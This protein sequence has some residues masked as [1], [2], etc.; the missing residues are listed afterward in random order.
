MYVNY[1]QAPLRVKTNKPPSGGFLFAKIQ[2]S[3]KV[4]VIRTL[5]VHMS[6]SSGSYRNNGRYSTHEIYTEDG[7]CVELTLC[8]TWDSLDTNTHESQLR[9]TYEVSTGNDTSHSIC[10]L[11]DLES[12]KR[13][14]KAVLNLDSQGFELNIYSPTLP[15]SDQDPSILEETK[16]WIPLAGILSFRDFLKNHLSDLNDA[17]NEPIIGMDVEKQHPKAIKKSVN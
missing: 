3:A 15:K 4:G 8:E 6:I 5:E 1:H 11:V 16:I 2:Q 9:I 14:Y 10:G 7:L 17:L 13:L 12:L